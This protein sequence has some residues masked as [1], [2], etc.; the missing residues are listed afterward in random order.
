MAVNMIDD[1]TKREIQRRKDAAI[2]LGL[3]RIVEYL[4]EEIRFYPDWKNKS[5]ENCFT[6]IVHPRTVRIDKMNGVVFSFEETEY[7][8]GASQR[9]SF[10][11]DSGLI[12]R[13]YFL[14]NANQTLLFS[15]SGYVEDGGYGFT[16]FNFS[17]ITAYIPGD[18]TNDIL[19]LHWLLKEN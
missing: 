9:N 15:I 14:Y 17:G 8:V 1:E 2:S 16:N 18:W 7:T 13:E 6:E 5:P 3:P 11:H 4:F 10:L 12:F 19:K